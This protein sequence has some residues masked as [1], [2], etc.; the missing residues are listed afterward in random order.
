MRSILLSSWRSSRE[1]LA[2][3]SRLAKLGTQGLTNGVH[4]QPAKH[5][6]E[7]DQMGCSDDQKNAAQTW[8]GA[9]TDVTLMSPSGDHHQGP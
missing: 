4:R 2:W 3:S 1:E 9:L 5:E 6:G 7:G 8:D